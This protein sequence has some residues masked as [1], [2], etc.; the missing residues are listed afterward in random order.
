VL[1]DL[2][3][4]SSPQ[5][6]SS[7][8]GVQLRADGPDMRMDPQS[9]GNG[10]RAI[11]RLSETELADLIYAYGEERLSRRIA[12]RIVR[13][14]PWSGLFQGTAALPIWWPAAI[15]PKARRGRSI[16]PPGTF[17]GPAHPP[18]NG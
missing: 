13:E 18:F 14:R 10:R 17:S 11:Y 1:A 2:G 9:G 6:D 4:L 3:A 8:T 12:R 7:P 16:Q 5:L 15:P